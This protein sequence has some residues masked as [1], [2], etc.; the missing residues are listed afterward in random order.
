MKNDKS[1]PSLQHIAIIMDGNRR[2]AKK[3]NL[4]VI[5]GHRAGADALQKIIEASIEDVIIEIDSVA[6]KVYM[7][8][9]REDIYAKETVDHIRIL[10][11]RLKYLYEDKMGVICE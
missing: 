9:P 8:D 6:E 5:A 4:P 1:Q 7:Y 11:Y 10:V 3:R 2:W